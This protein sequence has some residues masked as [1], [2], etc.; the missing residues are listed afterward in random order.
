V[1]IEMV[2]A[3]FDVSVGNVQT[4]ICEKLKMQKICVKFVPR[5]LSEDHKE[6]RCND[7]REMVE[8]INSSMY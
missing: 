3:Q 8:V 4:T 2:N 6:R 7:S 5:V 1:S